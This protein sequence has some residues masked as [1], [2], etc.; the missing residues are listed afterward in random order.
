VRGNDVRDRARF[1]NG[2]IILFRDTNEIVVEI[3]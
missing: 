2:R 3:A 1:E